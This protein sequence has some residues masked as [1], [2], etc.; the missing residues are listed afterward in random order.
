MCPNYATLVW[1]KVKVKVKVK[2]TAEGTGELRLKDSQMGSEGVAT[3]DALRFATALLRH[4]RRAT[5]AS[6]VAI[7]FGRSDT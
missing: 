4:A 1:V 6:E 3:N 2:G 7:A 5:P